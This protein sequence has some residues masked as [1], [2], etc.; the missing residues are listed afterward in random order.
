MKH[1]IE[2][3]LLPSADISRN[4]LWEKIFQP[5]HFGL[6]EMQSSNGTAPIG[7]SFPEFNSERRELG[8]KLRIFAPN[9][10]FLEK[11]D[12]DRRLERFMNY[13]HLTGIRQI[14]DSV[15]E[16]VRY[17]RC[18][19]NSSKERVARRK[20]RREGI[21]YKEALELLEGYQEIKL[22]NPF[23]TITSQSSGRRFPLFITK[24]ETDQPID[25]GFTAYG[26]SRKGT[27]PEF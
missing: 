17:K 23:I 5:I 13:V 4:F 3:T 9:K 12:A 26:L 6:V 24:E 15:S 18:Q 7:I 8:S 27:V 1:Y 20:A 14:P 2:I 21:G 16:Y 11:F 19:P 25:E 22:K 10:L